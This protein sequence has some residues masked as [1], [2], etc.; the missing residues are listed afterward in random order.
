R[1][2][3]VAC[4]KDLDVQKVLSF[5]TGLDLKPRRVEVTGLLRADKAVLW[6]LN[7]A[8]KK[9]LLRYKFCI[10]YKGRLV[11]VVDRMETKLILRRYKNSKKE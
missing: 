7:E 4:R 9:M 6:C 5:N 10:L 8:E 3:V 2:I 1:K 11:K